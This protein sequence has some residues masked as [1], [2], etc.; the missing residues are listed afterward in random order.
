MTDRPELTW[1][2][3]GERLVWDEGPGRN[4]SRV[5]ARASGVLVLGELCAG[6]TRFTAV[7][8]GVATLPPG[9]T[10]PQ[11]ALDALADRLREKHTALGKVLGVQAGEEEERARVVAEG[12]GTLHQRIVDAVCATLKDQGVDMFPRSSTARVVGVIHSVRRGI[13]EHMEATDA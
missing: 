7:Y 2:P 10:N 13:R 12:H 3:T 9:S 6:G 8:G 4:H 5:R 1:T 11:V